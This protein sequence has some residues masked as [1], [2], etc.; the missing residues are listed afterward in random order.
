MS[1]S[2]KDSFSLPS[3]FS[4]DQLGTT[5]G[6]D[7]EETK[8]S[9]VV[10][11]QQTKEEDDELDAILQEGEEKT[12]SSKQKKAK[13]HSIQ[14]QKEAEEQRERQRKIM[15]KFTPTQE[16]RFE[17]YKRTSFS[18]SNIRRI[19][20][21]IAGVPISQPMSVIMG[22]ITKIFVGELIE[23]ARQVQQL[24]Y[25]ETGPLQPKHL[26]EAYRI[27]KNKGLVPSSVHKRRSIL[28]K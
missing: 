14:Q 16:R 2:T 12:E 3:S 17:S 7:S 20:S 19:M 22:G 6:G 23:H 8:S 25:H 11:E 9:T 28:K 5:T 4:L 1:S 24:Y 10:E 13:L 15:S 27:M 18:R 21:G 26:R